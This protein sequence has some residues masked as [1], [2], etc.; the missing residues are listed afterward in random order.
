MCPIL[1]V[2]CGSVCRKF[3]CSA[4]LRKR[5]TLVKIYFITLVF[6]F[7]QEFGNERS[8]LEGLLKQIK[9]QRGQERTTL[10][11]HVDAIFKFKKC[12]LINCQ[13][14]TETSFFLRVVFYLFLYNWTFASLIREKATGSSASLLY[15]LWIIFLETGHCSCSSYKKHEIVWT[16]GLHETVSKRQFEN[17]MVVF[18]VAYS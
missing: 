7:V 15:V 6:S 18:E 1:H 16:S 17:L 4:Y 2:Q 9:K 8:V 14:D 13:D 5:S 11:C 3:A 10:R 12:S